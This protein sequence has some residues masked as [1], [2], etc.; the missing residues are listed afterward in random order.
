MFAAPRGRPSEMA[1]LWGLVASFAGL[2]IAATLFS[3]LRFVHA[4]P[5]FTTFGGLFAALLALNLYQRARMPENQRTIFFVDM[6]ALYMVIAIMMAIYQYALATFNARPISGLI[7]HADHAIGFHWIAYAAFVGR[8]TPLSEAMKFC[9][10]NWTDGFLVA[11]LAMTYL[12]EYDE[13][14]EFSFAYAIGGMAMLS[15]SAVFDSRSYE[16]VATYGLVGFHHPVGVGP[17][18][19]EKLQALRSGMDRTLDFSRVL[20]LIAFPS[21]HAGSALLVAVATRNLRWL[22]LPFLVFNELILVGVIS[23]GGHNFM[24]L[25]GGCAFAIA[26]LAAARALRRARG[27]ESGSAA[28]RAPGQTLPHLLRP[29]GDAANLPFEI[30]AKPLATEPHRRDSSGWLA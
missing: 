20:G 16:A 19:M 3:G 24:D 25:I 9:Y 18:T 8:L 28:V 21:L 11:M 30:E 2:T 4:G 12:R 14:Y 1:A 6:V 13:L 27:R 29:P 7:E 23:E 22:W 15:V 10:L 17:E 26:G 5:F